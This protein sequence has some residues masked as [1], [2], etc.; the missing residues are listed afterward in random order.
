MPAQPM[1]AELGAAGRLRRESAKD[2]AVAKD[3]LKVRD[4]ADN[5]DLYLVPARPLAAAMPHLVKEDPFWLSRSRHRTAYATEGMI[6]PTV[7]N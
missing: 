4:P 2:V 3:F 6:D 7:P 1:R 5:L